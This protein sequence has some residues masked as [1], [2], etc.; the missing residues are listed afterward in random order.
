MGHYSIFLTRF[1]YP[2]YL[3][4]RYDVN[5]KDNSSNCNGLKYCDPFYFGCGPN[6]HRVIDGFG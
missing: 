1:N 5:G 4:L 2:R 6:R 3:E